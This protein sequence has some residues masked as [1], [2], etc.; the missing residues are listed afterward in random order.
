LGFV[1]LKMKN[2]ERRTENRERNPN[3]ITFP[4][5]VLHSSF[6]TQMHRA[7]NSSAESG[8]TQFLP[9]IEK[10]LLKPKKIAV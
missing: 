8:R 1:A 2:E 3:T 4:F 7:L 10:K 9:A 6:D 5:S